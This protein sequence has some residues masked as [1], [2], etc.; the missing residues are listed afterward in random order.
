MDRT[1]KGKNMLRRIAIRRIVSIILFIISMLAGG[2]SAGRHHRV[3]V[4]GQLPVLPEQLTA[5]PGRLTLISANATARVCWH[6][7]PAPQAPDILPLADG[8]E[9]GFV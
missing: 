9:L 8:K 3:R 1:L 5:R 6:V 4:V 7:C 2:Y